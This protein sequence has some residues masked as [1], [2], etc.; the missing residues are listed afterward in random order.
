MLKLTLITDIINYPVHI[1]ISPSQKWGCS[2]VVESLPNRHKSLGSKHNAVGKKKYFCI[3][4]LEARPNKIH[5]L[6][7]A[8]CP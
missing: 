1:E 7:L 4:F 8:L 3:G 6:N 2:S 5:I